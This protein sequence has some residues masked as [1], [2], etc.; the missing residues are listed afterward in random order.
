MTKLLT[1][2]FAVSLAFGINTS[3]AQNVK[4]DKD[5]A[6]GQEQKMQEKEKGTTG[7]QQTGAGDRE[8][9][10]TEDTRSAPTA[11]QCKDMKGHA[12]EECLKGQANTAP[13]DSGTAQQGQK[14]KQQ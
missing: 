2:A 4:S 6:Q 11:N 3:I 8:R 7:G 12:K 9:M 10:K 14:A 13:T 1:A 5:Q